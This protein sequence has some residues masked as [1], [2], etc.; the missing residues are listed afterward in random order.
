M[1]YKN[2]KH[3]HFVPFTYKVKNQFFSSDTGEI[4]QL[5]LNLR[6]RLSSSVY[7]VFLTCVL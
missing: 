7:I 1:I 4:E 2:R 3:F 5:G 6:C